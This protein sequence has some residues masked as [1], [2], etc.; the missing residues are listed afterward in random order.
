[1]KGSLNAGAGTGGDRGRLVAIVVDPSLP[2][3]REIAR[4]AA[5][6]A[7]E[8]GGWQLYMEEEQGRR[9]PD[10]ETWPGQGIIASFDDEAV[11]RRVMATRLPVV[12]VG[13]GLGGDSIGGVPYVATDNKRIAVLAAEHLLDRG[14]REFGFYGLPPAAVTGW[15]G[16]RAEAFAARV[17]A[18]GHVCH[19]LIAHHDST[20][21]SP[22]Q[23]ELTAWLAL[24]PAPVGIMACDDLRARHV[25]EACRTLG[26]RVPQD[27]AVIGVDDDHLIC[28]LS[29][30]PLS[31]VAQASREIGHTAARLLHA[32][33]GR[34]ADRRT[35]GGDSAVPPLT[36]VPPLGVVPRRSTDMQAKTEPENAGLSDRERDV[37]RL[38]AQG[39]VKREVAQRLGL[40]PHTIDNYLRRIYA[41]FDVHTVG[42][43]VAKAVRD[44]VL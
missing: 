35:A 38:L 24:L 28:A 13:G 16:V 21:W 20:H 27:V 39:L 22:L 34:S 43:A 42:A 10:F 14:I 26:L 29:D 18:A 7:R 6:Y 8:V 12:A 2:Y 11:A 1:M 5:E 25:L 37:L 3:D 15:S 19:T 40:S 32:L 9:L 33:M 31:S 4:G 41:K 17:A 30:P 36:V 44:G 23:A